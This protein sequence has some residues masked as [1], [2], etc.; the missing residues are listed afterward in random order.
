MLN[1]IWFEVGV[2]LF[3]LLW[4]MADVMPCVWWYMLQP[5]SLKLL[6]VLFPFYWLMLLPIYLWQMLEPHVTA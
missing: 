6:P 5:L 3:H 1:H 4:L 2:N